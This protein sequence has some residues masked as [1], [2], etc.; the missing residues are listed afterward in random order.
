MWLP[1]LAVETRTLAAPTVGRRSTR[2]CRADFLKKCP[3]APESPTAVVSMLE[4]FR[5]FYTVA[6]VRWLI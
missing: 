3:D 4:R 1:S 6:F 2:N 5:P